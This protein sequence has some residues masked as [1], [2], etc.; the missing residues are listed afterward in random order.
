MSTLISQSLAARDLY[1]HVAPSAS[2]TNQAAATHLAVGAVI[3]AVGVVVVLAVLIRAATGVMG[4]F[5]EAL[6]VVFRLV[7]TLIA[8]IV[9]LGVVL[10][11]RTGGTT[12]GTTPTP[13]PATKAPTTLL[14]PRSIR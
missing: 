5:G 8:I 2:G 9:V 4:V 1:G 12:H 3:L 14:A 7:A 11:S 13:T 10:A 6:G